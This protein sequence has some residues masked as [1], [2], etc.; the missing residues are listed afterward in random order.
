MFVLL[1]ITRKRVNHHFMPDFSVILMHSVQVAGSGRQQ[2][3]TEF[4]SG[5]IG[6]YQFAVH[7]SSPVPQDDKRVLLVRL[8]S[9]ML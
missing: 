5:S 4:D 3:L 1:D 8:A 6:D 2:E 7:V 9:L